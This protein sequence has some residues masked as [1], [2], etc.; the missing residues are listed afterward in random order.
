M[1]GLACGSI[2]ASAWPVLATEVDAAVALTDDETDLAM[3]DLADRGIE[4]GECGAAPLAAIRQLT[5]S[6]AL[7]DLCGSRPTSSTACPSA[8][9]RPP[10]TEP[11][12]PAPATATL[13]LSD[14]AAAVAL[15][16]RSRRR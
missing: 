4:V 5:R 7:A 11:T 8:A 2:S 12:A 16:A 15:R 10:T 13:A 14:I 1:A 3:R 6:G 9:S